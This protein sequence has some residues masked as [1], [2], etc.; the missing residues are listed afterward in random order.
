MLATTTTAAITYLL[1]LINSRHHCRHDYHHA[2]QQPFVV[3]PVVAAV[4]LK[5]A[6]TVLEVVT[7]IRH[8]S[9]FGVAA[10]VLLSFCANAHT[11]AGV[12]A[13]LVW[14]L[15]CVPTQAADAPVTV[16]AAL[17]W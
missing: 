13:A 3:L 17:A 15:L 11:I 14:A 12:V 1:Q 8:L 9:A 6:F 10:S 2:R 4:I 7:Q 5:P 16:T